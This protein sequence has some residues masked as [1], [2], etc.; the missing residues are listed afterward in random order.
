MRDATAAPIIN[1]IIAI[2]IVR[3]IDILVSFLSG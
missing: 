1:V 3:Y 2:A